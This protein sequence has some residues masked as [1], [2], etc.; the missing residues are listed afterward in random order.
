MQAQEIREKL[1]IWVIQV[2]HDNGMPLRKW[3]LAKL[4]PKTVTLSANGES[5]TLYRRNAFK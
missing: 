1:P 4:T 3:E 2:A 5:K